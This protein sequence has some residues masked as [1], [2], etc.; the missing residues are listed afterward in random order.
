MKHIEMPLYLILR[1]SSLEPRF[2]AEYNSVLFKVWAEM[3]IQC[4]S[5]A[6]CRIM[7][8]FILEFPKHLILQ[9]DQRTA[10]VISTDKI[11]AIPEKN[12]KTLKN[13][14]S[15]LVYTIKFSRK[16]GWYQCS[17]YAC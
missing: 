4:T 17:E 10:M 11:T 6:N 14:I 7:L 3:K 5:V 2:F 9:D 13:E 8:F 15:D 12:K 16:K 1:P